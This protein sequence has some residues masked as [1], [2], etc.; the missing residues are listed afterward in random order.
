MI[1]AELI[2]KKRDG[3][4][5]NPNEIQW[6]VAGLS[7]GAVSEP[8]AA[9]FLMAAFLRGL[10]AKERAALTLA[11]RDS[12]KRYDFS[13]VNKRKVDKHST[14]G[15]GDKISLPLLPVVAAATASVAASATASVAVPMISG[16][17]LGHTGGTVDKLE[18]VGISMD[19]D[20]AR[21]S[22]LL[23][24]FGGFFA[25]QTPDIAPAD[26]TLYHLRDVT[27]TV[28]SVGLITASILSKKFC[29]DLDGLVMDVKVGKGAFMP[30]FD[31][32]R[33]L[34]ESMME[35]A[36]E[37]GLRMRVLFTRMDEPLG[38]TVGNWLEFEESL[39]ALQN[40][41]ATAPDI[42]ELT[43]RL[44]AA[45][46]LVGGAADSIE[47]ARTAVQTAWDSGKAEA[48][49]R[50]II[51]EQG[52]DIEASALRYA[53]TPH[54]AILATADGVITGIQAREVGLAGIVL[55]AGRLKGDDELDFSAG[56]IFHKKCGADVRKGD[57]I[58]IVQGTRTQTFDAAIAQIQAAI[59]IEQGAAADAATSAAAGLAASS[60]VLEEWDS[61]AM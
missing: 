9:A 22:V 38:R 58:G 30:T 7:N 20:N 53:D 2:R 4:E 36:R 6:F 48:A 8:Q 35:V 33:E 34:A 10:S 19:V 21:G 51:A 43:E 26:K 54:K 39:H 5:L 13:A 60:L 14:G 59:T 44:G 25:K 56:I 55:G 1:P 46:V 45:M 40:R 57:E 18:S 16:R 29:E 31:A 24:R 15:V 50:A 61:A 49:F 27:G 12:G 47:A 17:G 41:A 11:M 52:G 32:A 42:R 28:E 37:V 23:E 3:A